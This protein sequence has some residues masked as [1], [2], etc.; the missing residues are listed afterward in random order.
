MWPCPPSEPT[1]GAVV[2][3]NVAKPLDKIGLMIFPG[4][5]QTSSVQKEIDCSNNLTSGDIANYAASPIYTIVPLSSDYRA[6]TTA[7]LNGAGS[8]LVQA[9][10]WGHGNSCGSNR[11]GVESPGGVGTY[12]A[13][14]ITQAQSQL[15]A[16]G[17]PDVQNAIILLSD[18]D[19]NYTGVTR[20]L[21]EG[22]DRRPDAPRRRARGSTRSPTA[23]R[24]VGK[25]HAGLPGHLCV[26]HHAADCVGLGQVLQ[27]A[28]CR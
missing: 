2:N 20:S 15:I 18:G 24:L 4:L 28:D 13:D 1:C 10:D 5:A 21:P 3:G 22:R 26:Y 7:G 27:P 6:S 17:R 19:S 9:V 25:L 23:H 14:V 8:N 12:F 11:Y 16:T